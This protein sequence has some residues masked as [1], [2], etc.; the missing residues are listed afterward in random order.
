MR[1]TDEVFENLKKS[2]MWGVGLGQGYSI[3]FIWGPDYRI[4][5]LKGLKGVGGRPDHF[6]G[7]YKIRPP[8]HLNLNAYSAGKLTNYR[9]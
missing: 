2:F 8:L 5:H 1:K 4:E 9:L 6:L 3:N 7:A